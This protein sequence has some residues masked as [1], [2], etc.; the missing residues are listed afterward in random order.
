MTDMSSRMTAAKVSN[1]VI[2]PDMTPEEI[3]VATQL[4]FLAELLIAIHAPETLDQIDHM[5]KT[6]HIPSE[7]AQYLVLGFTLDE[8]SSEVAEHW[9]LP[10]L[11]MEALKSENAVIFSQ[12]LSTDSLSRKIFERL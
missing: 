3:F 7:E 1:G 8:L 6:R 5:K 9:H 12:F 10:S 4:H 2:R 11:V